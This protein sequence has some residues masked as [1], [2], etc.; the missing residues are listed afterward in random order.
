[1][2]LPVPISPGQQHEAAAAA[3]AVQQVRQRLAVALAHEQV[4]RVGRDGERLLLQ[5]AAQQ[6][7]AD[8][9][10]ES[11]RHR[12][13][14]GGAAGRHQHGAQGAARHARERRHYNFDS[15]DRLALMRALAVAGRA[16]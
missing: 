9:G 12:L 4:A 15:Q 3:D 2:V 10:A 13:R 5:V 7:V 8:D 1:V 14:A 6:A 11:G 16:S